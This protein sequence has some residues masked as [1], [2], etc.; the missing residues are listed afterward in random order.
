LFDL[1]GRLGCPRALKD[2]GMPR[3]GIRRAS[4]LAVSSPYPNPA[5]VTPDGVRRLLEQ[6]WEGLAPQVETDRRLED[7]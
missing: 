1:A 5:E 6:A 4:E 3:D 2:I 7:A